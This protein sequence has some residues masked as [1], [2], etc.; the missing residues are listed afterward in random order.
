M[1]RSQRHMGDVAAVMAQNGAY[2]V[3]VASSGSLD[4]RIRQKVILGLA[5]LLLVFTHL[6]IPPSISVI[7]LTNMV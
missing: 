1:E 6:H 4:N 3:G 2:G 7:E 5:N